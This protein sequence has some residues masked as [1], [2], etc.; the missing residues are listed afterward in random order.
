MKYQLDRNAFVSRCKSRKYFFQLNEKLLCLYLMLCHVILCVNTFTCHKVSFIS[1]KIDRT[2]GRLD[3]QL[4]KKYVFTPDRYLSHY[5]SLC[6][7]RSK[8]LS[9]F[10]GTTILSFSSSKLSFK[11]CFTVHKTAIKHSTIS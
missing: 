7:L 2:L 8:K 6:A 9:V 10:C 1:I 5:L 3:R 11:M 4:N